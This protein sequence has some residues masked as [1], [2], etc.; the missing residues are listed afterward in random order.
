MGASA[1]RVIAGRTRSGARCYHPLTDMPDRARDGTPLSHV[2]NAWLHMED[3]TNLMMVTGI[4][5]L[6]RPLPLELLRDT[7]QARMTDRFPRLRHRVRQE[8]SQAYW[9]ADRTFDVAAHVHRLALPEPRGAAELRDVVSDLMSTPLDFSKPLWQCHLI[10]GVDEGCAVLLRLHHCIGDGVALVHVLLSMADLVPDAPPLPP[11]PRRRRRAEEVGSRLG[12][13]FGRA[14]DAVAGTVAGTVGAVTGT[15]RVSRQIGAIVQETV[16]AVRHPSHLLELTQSAAQGAQVLFEMLMRPS[17]PPTP[18]KGPLG[19]RKRAAWTRP[20]QVQDVKDCGQAVGATINDVL[21]AAVTGALRRYL[22]RRRFEVHGLEINAMVPVNLRP[23]ERA[24]DLGNEF[25]LIYLAL[26]VGEPEVAERLRLVKQRM[27]EIKRSPE[28]LVAFQVLNA[29]GLAPRE[30]ADTLINMFGAKSTAVMTN[31]AGPRQPIYFAGRKVESVLFWVPQSGRMG[32]GVSILSY[33][34]R[35]VV[36]VATDAGLVPDPERLAQDFADEYAALAA[37]ARQKA[38]EAAP[39]E[40][41]L[42]GPPEPPP[43]RPRARKAAPRAKRPARAGAR[44]GR[45]PVRPA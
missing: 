20:I 18:F 8:G 2:D 31:V 13:A 30:M 22:V 39:L 33:N 43:A 16:Q 41:V 5:R 21:L 37:W 9:V 3:P 34:G 32:L 29:L 45:K 44:A 4:F 10:E 25:G 26:P 15:M 36:G 17:D 7:L 42:V 35:V 38:A 14:L 27:D 6:D 28:P 19:V 24:D 12:W 1:G 40:F 11:Q 23:L